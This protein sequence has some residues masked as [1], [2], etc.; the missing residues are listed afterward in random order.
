MISA[1]TAI[2]AAASRSISLSPL[3]LAPPSLAHSLTH[4]LLCV[5]PSRL[6]LF[7]WQSKRRQVKKAAAAAG[8]NGAED[9]YDIQEAFK[10]FDTDRDGFISIDEV[11]TVIRALGKCPTEAE[12]AAILEGANGAN[13]CRIVR[14]QSVC[15]WSLTNRSL[16]RLRQAY[17]RADVYGIVPQEDEEARRY[18]A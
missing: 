9:D 2:A 11:G 8:A 3:T 6:S 15:V 5:S 16:M 13:G 17:R 12:L 10:V 7:L 1:L 18:G 14:W 4:T